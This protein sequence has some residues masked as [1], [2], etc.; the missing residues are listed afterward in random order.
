MAQ[1]YCDITFWPYSVIETRFSLTLGGKKYLH[2]SAKTSW[3]ILN[4]GKNPISCSSDSKVAVSLMSVGAY[5]PCLIV[6]SREL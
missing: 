6:E 2:V 5:L 3:K 1:K 4:I